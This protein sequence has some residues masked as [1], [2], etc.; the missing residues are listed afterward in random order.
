[1]RDD[2]DGPEKITGEIELARVRSRAAQVLMLGIGTAV[3]LTALLF[4]AG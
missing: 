4:T 2:G 1:L 3:V